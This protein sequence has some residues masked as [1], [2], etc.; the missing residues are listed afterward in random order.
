[1]SINKKIAVALLCLSVI[2]SFLLFNSNETYAVTGQLTF[3]IT[4]VA[5]IQCTY[6]THWDM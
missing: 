4:G 2:F 5:N 3:N 1:M 6:P